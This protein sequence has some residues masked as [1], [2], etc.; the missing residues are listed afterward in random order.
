M[1]TRILWIEVMT[2]FLCGVFGQTKEQ[3]ILSLG[4]SLVGTLIFLR[5]K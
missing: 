3:T 1:I 4:I 5:N 2:L